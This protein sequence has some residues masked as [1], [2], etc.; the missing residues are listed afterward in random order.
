MEHIGF[1]GGH[2]SL[3]EDGYNWYVSGDFRHQ[4]QILARHRHGLWGNIDYTPFGGT[5]GGAN[6]VGQAAALDPIFAYPQ[7]DTGHFINPAN[8]AIVNYLPGCDAQPQA[9]NKCLT[10][11]PNVP[12]QPSTTRVDLLGEFARPLSDHWTL[13]IQAFWFESSSQETTGYSGGL[14]NVAGVSTLV[15]GPGAPL[16][17]VPAS[18]LVTPNIITVPSTNPM[19]PNSMCPTATGAFRAGDPSWCGS[20]LVLFGAEQQVR[21]RQFR[22]RATVCADERV[23]ALERAGPQRYPRVAQAVR[24]ARWA[25]AAVRR[26]A[27]VQEGAGRTCAAGRPLRCTVRKRRSDLRDWHREGCRG[28]SGVGW[29]ADQALRGGRGGSL[30]SLPGSGL[31]VHAEFGVKYDPWHWIALRGT[32]G[33][34][35]R[36]PSAAEGGSSGELFGAGACTD[37]TLCPN[38]NAHSSS[39]IVTGPGD[40]STQCSLQMTG[41]QA[42]N[43]HLQNVKLTNWTAGLVLQPLRD[44]SLTGDY[45]NIKATNDII[46][47]FEAGGLGN[48]SSILRG[49]PIIQPYC[50]ATYAAG[51]TSGERVKQ[52]TPVGT[53]LALS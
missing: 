5:F 35:F 1:I 39:S 26:R 6:N 46:P 40:Y 15:F 45:Y 42:A 38:P 3:A 9:L 49:A 12:L 24:S 14:G 33:K 13:G 47:A 48:Y 43:P 52:V 4:D 32:W 25:A 28:I 37:P 20:L 18:A 41:F 50:P 31:G 8:G 7:S 36:A 29:Q 16:A 51:C 34:D 53:S 44:V 27:V 10:F 30:R 21:L 2:G 23:D 17:V 11:D 22:C 19:Y